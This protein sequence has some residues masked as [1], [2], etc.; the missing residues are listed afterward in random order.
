M[1]A[2]EAQLRA[3]AVFRGLDIVGFEVDRGLSAS[4]LERPGLQ[5]ALG[6]MAGEKLS[7]LLVVKLDRLT[8]SV[9][10]LCHLVETYF[11]EHS[12]ISAGESIDT[13]TA[14]GRLVL[15]ILVTVSQWEREA[16]AERTTAVMQHLKSTGQYTGGWPP[17]GHRLDEE[18]ALVDVPEELAIVA[19]A[20]AARAAGE[21]L[22]SIAGKLPVSP[23]TGKPFTAT[24]IMRML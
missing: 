17:F 9:R 14:S 5:R 3:Y 6:R 19:T 2:Q 18:G 11:T 7:G 15:N 12:L 24:Q 1:E 22:R 23:R 13:S 21:S 16:A 20:R 8:R 10:D 4:S